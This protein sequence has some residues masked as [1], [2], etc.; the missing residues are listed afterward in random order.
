MSTEQNSNKKPL[1]KGVEDRDIQAFAGQS[2]VARFHLRRA[3]MWKDSRLQ[4]YYGLWMVIGVL[5]LIAMTWACDSLFGVTDNM[6]TVLLTVGAMV[7]ISIIY[8]RYVINPFL[9]RIL[10]N[11]EPS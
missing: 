8:W 10:D 9:K 7:P 1:L 2:E 6:V 3:A 5:V 4:G 11:P